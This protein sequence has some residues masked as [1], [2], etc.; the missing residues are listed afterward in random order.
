MLKGRVR[1]SHRSIKS[2]CWNSGGSAAKSWRSVVHVN[3]HTHTP[4]PI[5]QEVLW[6]VQKLMTI[7][8]RLTAPCRYSFTGLIISKVPVRQKTPKSLNSTAATCVQKVPG[9][10]TLTQHSCLHLVCSCR[11]KV[12]LHSCVC[13]SLFFPPT[14]TRSRPQPRHLAPEFDLKVTGRRI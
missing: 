2:S 1:S 3:T 12:Q 14:H 8:G 4:L 11:Q 5:L 7:A 9:S 13:C 6:L 10:V